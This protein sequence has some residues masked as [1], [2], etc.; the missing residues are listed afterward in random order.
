MFSVFPELIIYLL[1]FFGY[2]FRRLV[3]RLIVY[4]V[5]FY[6]GSRTIEPVIFPI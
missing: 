3:I 5:C 4:V 2:I 1:L 6:T